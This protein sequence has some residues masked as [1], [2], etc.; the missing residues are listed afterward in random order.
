MSKRTDQPKKTLSRQA[1]LLSEAKDLREE[2]SD[3]EIEQWMQSASPAWRDNFLFLQANGIKGKDAMLVTWMALDRSSRKKAGLE[4]REALADFLGVSR[5][6]TYQW[7][8]RHTFG[9]ESQQHDMRYW[10]DVLRIRHMAQ[11]L[12]DV[13][14][15]LYHCAKG[16]DTTAQMIHLYYKRAGVHIDESKLHLVGEGDGPVEIRRAEDLSDDELASIAA[17][18]GAGTHQTPAGA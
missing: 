17:G 5:P 10:A 18:S 7:E 14:E 12:G 11:R 2:K 6:V 1:K 13:D 9:D 15:N 3:T 4:T 8:E 16:R